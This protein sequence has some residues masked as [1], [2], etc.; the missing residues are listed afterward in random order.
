MTQ[1]RSCRILRDLVS[2]IKIAC[3]CGRVRAVGAA[4]TAAAGGEKVEVVV[5]CTIWEMTFLRL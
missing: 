2:V 4:S 3:P 1:C 5:T